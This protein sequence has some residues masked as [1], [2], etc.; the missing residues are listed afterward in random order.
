MKSELI[1]LRSVYDEANNSALRGLDFKIYKGEIVGLAGGFHSGKTLLLEILAGNHKPTQGARF[2]QGKI[3]SWEKT[4]VSLHVRNLKINFGLIGPM[5]VW[6]NIVTYR[7]QGK[8]RHFLIQNR[9]RSRIREQL[10]RYGLEVS[11][12]TPIEHLSAVQKFAV[13]LIKAQLEDADLVLAET[14]E[15]EYSVPGF[16]L[17]HRILGTAK[18]NG[19]SILFSGTDAGWLGPLMDRICLIDAGQILWEE[20]V[21]GKGIP[22][23]AVSA[24]EKL[25]FHKDA[26]KE[27]KKSIMVS[28]EAFCVSGEEGEFLAILDTDETL[29]GE[30][31]YR[32][33]RAF[34]EKTGGKRR[35]PKLRQ[36]DFANFG[37]LVKWMSPGDNLIFGLADKTSSFG[38]T[39]PHL[40]NYMLQKFVGW[41]GDERYL[42]MK[43]CESLTIRERIKIASF[44]LKMEKPEILLFRHLQILDQNSR[45]MVLSVLSDLQKEGTFLIGIF[46]PVECPDSAD[47]YIA[48]TKR[49]SSERMS[50][51]EMMETL[52]EIKNRMIDAEVGGK[53]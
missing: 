13:A 9:M 42:S 2:V 32:E 22:S 37:T 46:T 1:R 15:L 43:N 19:I 14:S 33:M 6:E 41:S 51:S 20:E 53:L 36:I 50:Y 29:G 17:M 30:F 35:V 28:G 10:K 16:E 52:A 25:P 8:K 4:A 3:S 49:T 18:A 44:R 26:E 27:H 23:R 34:F 47:G 31:P 24:T 21:W 7:D 40:R 12:G 45:K 38:I 48:V 11:L 5:T 39:K